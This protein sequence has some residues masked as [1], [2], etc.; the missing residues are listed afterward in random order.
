MKNTLFL[1]LA[2]FFIQINSK[3]QTY[4]GSILGDIPAILEIK[5]VKN[6]ERAFIKIVGKKKGWS[7]LEV[8][9]IKEGI[10]LKRDKPAENINF[11]IWLRDI[12]KEYDCLPRSIYAGAIY[13]KP[14][15]Q[16]QEGYYREVLFILDGL[17]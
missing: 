8:D 13:V 10:T 9:R 14:T 15:E 6:E 3:A 5:T 7:G 1:L 2:F 12:S 17:K 4:R 16:G 11:P